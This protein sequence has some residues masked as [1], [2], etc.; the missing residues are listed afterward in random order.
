MADGLFLAVVGVVQVV[1]ELLSYYAATGPYGDTFAG[2]PYIVGW[3]EAHGL[4]AIVGIALLSV[5]TRDGRRF[6]HVMAAVVHV[7]LG[8]ANLVFF[9]AFIAWGLVPAGVA[10]TVAHVVFVIAHVAAYAVS[11]DAVRQR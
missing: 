5:A 4:A 1:F 9:D 8:S 3:V 11:R 10:S 6:W 2:S 7:L